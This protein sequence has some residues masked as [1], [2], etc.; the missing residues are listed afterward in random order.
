MKGVLTYHLILD[1]IR[2]KTDVN[3]VIV[4][5]DF[6]LLKAVL[7]GELLRLKEQWGQFQ[8]SFLNRRFVEHRTS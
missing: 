1:V 5:R 7:V 2:W 8:L 6:A 4:A 3:V